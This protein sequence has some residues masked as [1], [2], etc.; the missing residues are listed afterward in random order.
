MARPTSQLE[1]GANMQAP[2]RILTEKALADALVALHQA[3]P[4]P[5]G[6]ML[7]AAGQPPVRRRPAGLAG[8]A[9]IVV[10]QQV[11]A[12]SAAAINGRLESR[13][14]T[15]QPELI[16]GATDDDLRACGLSAP[17]MRTLRAISAAIAGGALDLEALEQLDAEAAR[18]AL[19]RIKGI[20]PWSADVYLLFCLGRPDV[21]PAGDLALQEAARMALRLRSRP[22]AKRLEK[23]GERW[24]PWRA[25]AARLLWA[26]YGA[27]R[28]NVRRGA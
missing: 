2:A 11:S 12:A 28:E 8:L 27:V 20:G 19:T 15:F 5:I 26:Y 13:F 14:P 6:R 3:D 18:E 23:I 17:K 4:L 22:D 25:A 1:P 9:W 10:S 16:I 21:W 24:R 7:E